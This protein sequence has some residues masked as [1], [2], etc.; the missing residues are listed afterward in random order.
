MLVTV[1]QRS[2]IY[3]ICLN[4]LSVPIVPLT[5]Q[6]LCFCLFHTEG[7]KKNKKQKA[8]EA[9]SREQRPQRNIRTAFTVQ[10]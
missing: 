10:E 9:A 7:V 8:S 4:F 1:Y 6:S 3:W 5:Y 2:L